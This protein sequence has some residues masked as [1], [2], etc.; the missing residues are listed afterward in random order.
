MTLKA[1]G[2]TRPRSPAHRGRSPHS[3]FRLQVIAA[4]FLFVLWYKPFFI[5]NVPFSKDDRRPEDH[6][7]HSRAE[8]RHQHPPRPTHCTKPSPVELV[9]T[10]SEPAGGCVRSPARRGRGG[11]LSCALGTE[12][13]LKWMRERRHSCMRLTEGRDGSAP[14]PPPRANESSEWPQCGT[15]VLHAFRGSSWSVAS[16]IERRESTPLGPFF[17]SHRTEA[18]RG[19]VY[20]SRRTREWLIPGGF[21]RLDRAV[22]R[23]RIPRS[24]GAREGLHREPSFTTGWSLCARGIREVPHVLR[25]AR[26]NGWSRGGSSASSGWWE[27]GERRGREARARVCVEHRCL[28]TTTSTAR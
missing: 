19:L 24:R 28:A 15:G 27:G 26:A 6:H 20:V 1:M 5:E 21:V 22:G 13:S 25:G 11:A 18:C 8:N 9:R 17:E 10:S 2:R 23:G 3:H 4:Y 14:P 7:Q 12:V 16:S